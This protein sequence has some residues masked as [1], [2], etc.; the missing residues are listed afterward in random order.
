MIVSTTENVPGREVAEILGLVTGNIVQ[1]RNIG[2]D[3]SSRSPKRCRREGGRLLRDAGRGP[4]R[5]NADYGRRC[6]A[7]QRRRRGQ[8][9]LHHQRHQPR[10]V[11]NPGLRHRGQTAVRAGRP[12]GTGR[13]EVSRW[14]PSF[15]A[16]CCVAGTGLPCA[17]FC[18]RLAGGNYLLDGGVISSAPQRGSDVPLIPLRRWLHSR[19]LF[20]FPQVPVRVRVFTPPR[21]WRSPW[22]GRGFPGRSGG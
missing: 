7:S 3:P 13:N 22:R 11:G 15:P 21:G 4:R 19:Q 6:R 5:S 20:P 16:P 9:A 12:R 18:V 17:E 8:C 1:T 2:R 14:F 10:H